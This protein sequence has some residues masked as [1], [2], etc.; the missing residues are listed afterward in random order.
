MSYG[1]LIYSKMKV[2]LCCSFS[3]CLFENFRLFWIFEIYLSIIGVL[4]IINSIFQCAYRI[5]CRFLYIWRYLEKNIH[6]SKNVQKCEQFSYELF[7]C[8]FLWFWKMFGPKWSSPPIPIPSVNVKVP[9]QGNKIW[10]HKSVSVFLLF[11]EYCWIV[12]KFKK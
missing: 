2:Y 4:C 10:K 5:M 11:F 8:D 7:L 9:F 3:F 12:W 6:F 1:F